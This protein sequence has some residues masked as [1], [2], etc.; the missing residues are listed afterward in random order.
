M[1]G[2]RRRGLHVRDRGGCGCSDPV[3][4]S[5][6]G[7]VAGSRPRSIRRPAMPQSLAW[8]ARRVCELDGADSG[9]SEPPRSRDA[10]CDARLPPGSARGRVGGRERVSRPSVAVN[11]VGACLWSARDRDGGGLVASF[12]LA[13]RRSTCAESSRRSFGRRPQFRRLRPVAT[14]I[15][16]DAT[17]PTAGS[18]LSAIGA[19]WLPGIW[20][21]GRRGREH[22]G[23]RAGH[24]SPRFLELDRWIRP[25]SSPRSDS[26]GLRALWLP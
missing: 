13:G 22:R 12:P 5:F 8:P 24:A 9:A 21:Q 23:E 10:E 17:S 15:E 1:A 20:S 14:P 19:R 2:D 25:P 11:F 4:G 7:A 26:R 16:G 18:D 6:A 3:R